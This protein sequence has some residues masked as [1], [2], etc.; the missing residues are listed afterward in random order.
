[1]AEPLNYWTARKDL[2][3][4]QPSQ[5]KQNFVPPIYKEVKVVKDGKIMFKIEKVE[6]D[7]QI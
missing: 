7:Y 1:M 4:I 2:K 3:K 5:P 6:Q